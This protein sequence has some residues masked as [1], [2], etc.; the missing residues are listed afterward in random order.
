MPVVT[1]CVN[2]G[3]E[4]VTVAI[5]GMLTAACGCGSRNHSD[6][7]FVSASQEESGKVSE[8]ISFGKFSCHCGGNIQKKHEVTRVG[9]TH[10]TKRKLRKHCRETVRGMMT[11]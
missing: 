10:H 5:N 3:A 9:Y 11:A 8:G 4:I 1:C 2:K 6:Y 7:D